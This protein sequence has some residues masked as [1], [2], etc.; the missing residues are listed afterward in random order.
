MTNN[1]IVAFVGL[2]CSGK[3]SIIN[4]LV[5]NQILESSVCKTTKKITYIGATNKLNIDNKNFVENIIVSDDNVQFDII[6][7]PGICD[8]ISID[9]TYTYVINAN[10]IFWVSD[11]NKAFLTQYEIEEFNKL[12]NYLLL[13]QRD[14]GIL[15]QLKIILSKCNFDIQNKN[16]NLPQNNHNN[17][18]QNINEDTILYDLIDNVRNILPS[19]EIIL[20]NA[21]GRCLYSDKISNTFR[22]FL[23]SNIDFSN[24]YN[25]IV[26]NLKKYIEYE[27]L[28]NTKIYIKSFEYKYEQYLLLPNN[29]LIKNLTTKILKLYKIDNTYYTKVLNK[30]IC[31]SLFLNYTYNSTTDSFLKIIDKYAKN[32]LYLHEKNHKIIVQLKDEH[33]INTIVNY[34]ETCF[35]DD[36][37]CN[38]TNINPNLLIIIYRLLKSINNNNHILSIWTIRVYMLCKFYGKFLYNNSEHAQEVQI[39]NNPIIISDKFF[40]NIIKKTRQEL[41]PY[42]KSDTLAI[43]NLYV[44]GKIHSIFQPI[45]PI[46][47][48]SILNKQ[49]VSESKIIGYTKT[50]EYYQCA[51]LYYLKKSL[52]NFNIYVLDIP[53]KYITSDFIINIILI[54]NKIVHSK[55][56]QYVI[57]YLSENMLI[58]KDLVQLL[59]SFAL[60]PI[61]I[62]YYPQNLITPDIYV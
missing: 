15:Y 29:K 50:K 35:I 32:M 21:Y 13:L 44:Q 4:S 51:L 30:L 19:E 5:G 28:N 55:M 43:L 45:N 22:N 31:S 46:W 40:I 47:F 60:T 27:K 25:N 6:Y 26:F 16:M 59:D 33:I 12:K 42:E 14:T 39:K 10:I 61:M 20:Y 41:Y 34:F 24:K 48:L 53:D 18:I 8:N 3:S 58:T 2:Q 11:V 1:Y 17:E 36:I 56:L 23:L 54:D 57:Q 49:Y 62:K 37:F 7:L 52:L 9:I 38:F